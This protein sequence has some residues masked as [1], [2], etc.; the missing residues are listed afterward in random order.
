MRDTEREEMSAL[1]RG[2]T[3]WCCG[4]G[5][6]RT[7]QYPFERA[8]GMIQKDGGGLLAP[9][10]HHY[11]SSSAAFS[12][13]NSNWQSSAFYELSSRF[14][15]PPCDGTSAA[16]E[17]QALCDSSSANHC[18]GGSSKRQCR[19]DDTCGARLNHLEQSSIHHP[20][21]PKPRLVTSPPPSSS[22][23]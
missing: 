13:M 9:I 19:V 22:Q 8:V 1:L 21:N 2:S 17:R 5:M 4:G 20:P 10:Q 6:C 3:P 15:H 23:L 18:G 14:H 11:Y 16:F 7:E 12:I